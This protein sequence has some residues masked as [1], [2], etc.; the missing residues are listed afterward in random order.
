MIVK[1]EL[2]ITFEY[3]QYLDGGREVVFNFANI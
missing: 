1:K 3:C 2:V